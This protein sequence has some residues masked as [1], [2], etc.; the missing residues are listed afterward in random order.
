MGVD[1][2]NGWDAMVAT[3]QAN[4]NQAMTLAYNAGLLPKSLQ[5]SFTITVFGMQ[6]PASVN[7]TL[8][9]WRFAGGSGKNVVVSLPFTGGTLT[10][11]TTPYPLTGLVLQVTCLLSY[12]KSP[13]QPATGTNY[14][15]QIDFTAPDAI[16]AVQV[17][18]PPPG[19]DQNTIDIV[20]LNFL[21]NALGGHT[22]DIATVNLGYVE[23]NYPYLVPTLIEYA[24]DTNSTDPNSTIFGVQML[25]TNKIPGNQDIVPG[26]V[27][28]G[29]PVCDSAALV[30]NELF[31]KKLLL[32]GLAGAL[33]GVTASQLMASY[34]GGAWSVV[35][36]GDLTLDMSHSPTV[37]S[38]SANVDNN[39][40][41]V[42][43]IGHAEVSAG[44][45]VNFNM[46]ATYALQLTTSGATQ[47]INLVQQSQNVNHS[48]D[49]ATWVIITA[50]ALAA[51]VLAFVGPLAALIVAGIEA[52]VIYLIATIANNKAGNILKDSLPAKVSANVNWTN[53]EDFTIQQALLPT[54]LQLGGTIPV[55]EPSPAV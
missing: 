28:S 12:I 13:V 44:I 32:P 52:L 2:M 18:N 1:Y 9:P 36:N 10:I 21:K 27:P 34:A 3:S 20:L 51:L 42:S 4:L 23:E 37:T 31:T 46:T 5:T 29:S 54:P 14:T 7:A 41:N 11:G 39:L 47:S 43:I 48:V 16:V 49:V 38:L 17:Q 26:T 22:Y 45:T 50:A 24:V 15:F 6:F 40:V 55:L 30:S 35:N 33:P 25:T 8:D 53:L 19:L